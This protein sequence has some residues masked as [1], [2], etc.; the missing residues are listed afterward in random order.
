MS[1]AIE[2]N[3]RTRSKGEKR[4]NPKPRPV[5]ERTKRS[6]SCKRSRTVGSERVG[7]SSRKRCSSWYFSI[8]NL[9]ELFTMFSLLVLE[10]EYI[11]VKKSV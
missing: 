6:D 4:P 10:E 3:T 2:D 8:T 11:E 7:K 1:S 9:M 5:K